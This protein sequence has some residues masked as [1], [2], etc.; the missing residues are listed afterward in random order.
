MAE[1]SV[2]VLHEVGD[3]AGGDPWAAAFAQ[4]PWRNVLAPDL[5][6]HGS[7]PTSAGE[8][9]EMTDP[10]FVATRL[11]AAE[12]IEK[13]DAV[14]GIGVSGW[15]AQILAIAGRADRLVLV[16]G[17][18]DPF[19]NVDELLERR[20]E[21]MRVIAE[22][23]KP[24]ADAPPTTHGDRDLAVRAA[25]Q[26]E[27]PVLLIGADSAAHREFVET[28]PNATLRTTSDHDPQVIAQMVAEWSTTQ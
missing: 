2:L 27:V 5:P 25:G 21:R 12:G 14:V 20:M 15:S 28:L 22:S 9:Y 19:L 17:L 11:F 13:V 16:N 26:T 8:E 6:G 7:A 10:A 23:T 3:V 24:L 18:G 1:S 4:G